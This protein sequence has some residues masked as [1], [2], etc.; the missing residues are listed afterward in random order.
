M[1]SFVRYIFS[2]IRFKFS[3]QLVLID[4]CIFYYY[5]YNM[6]YLIFALSGIC[7]ASIFKSISYCK[8]AGNSF[9]SMVNEALI[10]F[11]EITIELIRLSIPEIL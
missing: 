6:K 11:T 9:L 10:S 5:Q 1:G 2:L 7:T 8:L 4:E 3:E